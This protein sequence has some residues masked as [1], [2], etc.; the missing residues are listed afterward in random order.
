MRGCPAEKRRGLGVSIRKQPGCSHNARVARGQ[1]SS[2]RASFPNQVVGGLWVPT[3]LL[4]GRGYQD[5]TGSTLTISTTPWM[6][7]PAPPPHKPSPTPGQRAPVPQLFWEA[8][9]LPAL[10]HPA[11]STDHSVSA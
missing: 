1:G 4:Q 6:A 2:R 11:L 3:V 10:P 7:S 5:R 9:L 8:E